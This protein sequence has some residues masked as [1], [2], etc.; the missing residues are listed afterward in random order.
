M[1]IKIALCGLCGVYASE[2]P[3]NMP[4]WFTWYDAD[5]KNQRECC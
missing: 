3:V 1:M 2:I 4:K 5:A